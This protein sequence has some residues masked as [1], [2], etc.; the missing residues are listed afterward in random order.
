MTPRHVIPT[1]LLLLLTTAAARA[2]V[3]ER[4]VARVNDRI[5]TMSELKAREDDA[6]RELL[7]SKTGP[8]GEALRT[9]A[10]DVRKRVIEDAVRE[11][12]FLERAHELDIKIDDAQVDDA[13][14]RLKKQN[15]V[16]TDDEFKTALA[17]SGLTV[18]MMR[19]SL[20][21]N[22]LIQ[23]IL[24]SEI[25]SRLEVTDEFLRSLYNNDKEKY[26]KPD[27]VRL[28]EILLLA[29]PGTPERAT[30][31]TK[32]DDARRRLVEGEDFRAVAR[33]VSQ[34][35][36]RDKGGDL[37]IV[38]R[39][40]LS[41]EIDSVVF[42]LDAGKISDPVESKFGWHLLRVDEKFP[43]AYT[44]FEDAKEKVREAYQDSEYSKRLADYVKKLREKMFVKIEIDESGA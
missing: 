11:M 34:G 26:R 25:Q 35:G 17:S 30:A 42:G 44:P 32:V 15:G 14:N 41:A 33:E 27:Q 31:R 38:T 8:Q 28:S 3:V 23:R 16:A 21:R 20:R 10:R 6:I 29:E 19:E 1:A 36:T 24:S 4:I 5:L 12:L 7:R 18:D 2:A 13:I 40:D 39:G 22:M 43:V 9:A 37:G